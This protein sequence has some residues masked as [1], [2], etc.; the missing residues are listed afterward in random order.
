MSDLLSNSFSQVRSQSL[1]TSNDAPIIRRSEHVS[2]ANTE[3]FQQQIKL[4]FVLYSETAQNEL[5]KRELF[6]KE[7]QVKEV[8]KNNG[9]MMSMMK[10]LPLSPPKIKRRLRA[11][12]KAYDKLLKR[13][14]KLFRKNKKT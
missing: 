1:T 3:R 6:R 5:K 8:N 10:D 7:N 13:L 14:S 9:G 4:P 12:E 2:Q 11:I